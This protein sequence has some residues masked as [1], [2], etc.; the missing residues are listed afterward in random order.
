MERLLYSDAITYKHT[1][2]Y[3][4][5]TIGYAGKEYMDVRVQVAFAFFAPSMHVACALCLCPMLL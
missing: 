1:I 5:H 2:G 3:A 4:Q